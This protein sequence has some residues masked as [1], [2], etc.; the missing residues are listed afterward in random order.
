M[1]TTHF[2]AVVGETS[3]TFEELQTVFYKIEAVMNSR[4]LSPLTTDPS[5]LEA[6]TPAHFLIAAPLTALPEEDLF[7]LKTNRLSR[8]QL[9]TRV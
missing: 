8:Y 4:P 2:K 5:D 7:D 3:L 1:A 9:L 6:L